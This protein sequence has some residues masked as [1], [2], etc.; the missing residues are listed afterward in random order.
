MLK[1][2]ANLAAN[3]SLQMCSNSMTDLSGNPQQSFCVNFYA[4]SSTVTTG[5]VVLQVSPPAGFTGIGTNSWI[6]ILWN[7]PIDAASIGGITGCK[8][9]SSLIPAVATMFDGDQGIQLLPLLPLTPN[10][11]YTVNVAG[12]LDI[13]GN[14]QASFPSQSFTTGTGADLVQPTAVSMNPPNG[15][16]S[17]A[18]NTAVQVVFS[19]AMDPASFD[20][21]NSFK[22]IDSSA[23]C[24]SPRPGLRPPAPAWPSRCGTSCARR[25]DRRFI[26][27]ARRWWNRSLD[28]SKRRAGFG[29]S[30][31][32]GWRKCRRNG[33]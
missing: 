7:E 9:G 5:P 16:A 3:H 17:V 26:N 13:T 33:R 23:R 8:N 31:C 28:R 27:C 21:A 29:D 32:A 25:K 1:P 4:G 22:L 6:Q 18:T 2:T 24:W 15:A 10:T 14:A 20:P 30:C 19:K 11:L 12:V